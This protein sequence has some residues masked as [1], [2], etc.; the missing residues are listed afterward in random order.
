MTTVIV[1]GGI[2]GAAAAYFL[3]ERR[4][5]NVLVLER[6]QLGSGTTKGGLGGIRHQFV[7]ELDVR[8]SRLAMSFWRVFDDITGARHDFHQRG[9]LFIANTD[10][11]LEQLRASMPLYE[12][13][14]VNVE[15]VGRVSVAELV[16]GMRVDDVVGGRFGA[17]DGYGDPPQALAGFAAFA[18]LAGV[19]IKERTNVREIMRSGDRVTGVRTDDD[20]IAADRVLLATGCWTAP[21]AA[22]AGVAVPIWPYR[23]SIMESQPIPQLSR[24]PMVIEWES[25]F[26]FRPKG[27]AVRFAMPNLTTDGGIEK[28]PP[29]PPSAYPG[30]YVPLDVP[31][32]LE[33]WVRARAAWRHPLFADVQIRSSWSCYYEMTPDD[34]PI[35]GPVPGVEGLFIAAGFSGHG[36]MHAPAI[37]Q[38]VVEQML[39]GRARALDISDL[40]LE[41][42]QT[43]RRPFTATVL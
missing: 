30:D 23:R 40:S 17:E 6:A 15:M 2:I 11:G 39:D 34:H 5:T 36:F 3:A 25:G 24:A 10:G 19:Q 26:H 38:L 4:E 9:Y 35:V 7:D 31:A 12:K 29:G 42:F 37:A 43:G 1:G 41:R 28:G 8:L 16:R 22:T 20:E 21:L 33:P 27:N 13:V 14:G 18:Q 32:S